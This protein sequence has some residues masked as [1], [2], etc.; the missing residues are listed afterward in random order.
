MPNSRVI[1]ALTTTPKTQY[2]LRCSFVPTFRPTTK[3]TIYAV[4]FHQSAVPFTHTQA[5][6]HVLP[7]HSPAPQ[8]PFSAIVNV[9]DRGEAGKYSIDIIATY[10]KETPTRRRVAR[11]RTHWTH[12]L[13]QSLPSCVTWYDRSE[14]W[15]N[16]NIWEIKS[17]LRFG[18]C[19]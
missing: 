17:M 2:H 7:R 5:G 19:T 8:K 4:N 3:K 12:K 18:G 14:I 10:T 11:S 15:G 6:Q 13:L 9:H 1:L 16:G